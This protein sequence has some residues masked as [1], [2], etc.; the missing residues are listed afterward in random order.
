MKLLNFFNFMSSAL[1]AVLIVSPFI[2]LAFPTLE[3]SFPALYAYVLVTILFWVLSLCAID[4]HV[5][6]GGY[7]N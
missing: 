4:V 5:K 2:F 7:E 3:F 1:T 6:N